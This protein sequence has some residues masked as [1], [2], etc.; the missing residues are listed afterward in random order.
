VWDG[1]VY[2]HKQVLTNVTGLNNAIAEL[3]KATPDKDV[4][5]S[6]LDAVDLTWYGE[7]FSYAVYQKELTRH[8]PGYYRITW[9]GQGHLPVP[10]DVMPEYRQIENDEYAAALATLTT[11]RAAELADLVARVQAMSATLAGLTPQVEALR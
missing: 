1:T 5:L 7:N 3:E 10:L 11:K 2:P 8:D 4:A 9:G 6:G